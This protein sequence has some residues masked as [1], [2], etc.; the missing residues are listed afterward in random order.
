MELESGYQ[1]TLPTCL[2]SVWKSALNC[3]GIPTPDIIFQHTED[4]FPSPLFSAFPLTNPRKDG[5]FNASTTFSK[6]LPFI[7]FYFSSLN[8]LAGTI[9]IQEIKKKKRCVLSHTAEVKTVKPH[10]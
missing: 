8:S 10:D 2:Q 4:V 1:V 9:T 5:E 3:L 6:N 7:N